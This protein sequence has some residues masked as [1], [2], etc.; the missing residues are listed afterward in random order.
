VGKW[1]PKWASHTPPR[2]K[3]E[4]L[5]LTAEQQAWELDQMAREKQYRES[6]RLK[7]PR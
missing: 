4:L 6:G 7:D 5:D 3:W 2:P 1:P